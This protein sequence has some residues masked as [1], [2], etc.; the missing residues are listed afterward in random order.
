MVGPVGEKMKNVEF[1]M[2]SLKDALIVIRSGHP[3]GWGK[4]LE[5]PNNKDL[6]GLRCNSQ[7]LKKPIPIAV[8]GQVL[9]LSYYL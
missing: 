3:E 5:M 8:K 9:P 2:A 1:R 7:D 6:S 4:M